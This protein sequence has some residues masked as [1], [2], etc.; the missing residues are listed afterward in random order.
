M[1]KKQ[2]SEDIK[3]ESTSVSSQNFEPEDERKLVRKLDGRIM[4]ILSI[5]YLFAYLDRSNLG[6][7][8]LL[9]LPKDTLNGDPTGKRFDWVNSV[10]FFAYILCQV[11]AAI[12]SKLVPPR[13]WIAFM[14]IGW[15]LS[16]TLMATAF[17]FGGL[18]TGRVFLGIFEA[19]FGPVIPL[20]FSFF[21]T[22]EEMGVR[23][24]YWFG[25][26]AVAGA[27][28][29]LISFGVQHV[30]ATIHNWSILFL[31][32]GVP[33]MLMGLV[34]FFF[35]PNR[36]ESTT[37]LNE[38]ERIIALDRMNR[39]TSGDTGAKV[40]KAHILMAFR[41]WRCWT[42]GVIY[43]GLN[44]ALA[45][46]SAFLP[47][48]IGTFGYTN[49]IA[50]L[51]TGKLIYPISFLPIPLYFFSPSVCRY[52]SVL[53]LHFIFYLTSLYSVAA[54]L[55]LS[56][57]WASDR[58]QSRGILMTVACTISGIGY[59]LLL[60]IPTNAH[61]R[62]FAVYCIVSGTYA[63]IGLIIA[64]FAHNLGSETKRATGIP[65]FMATG[66]CG[67]V[68]GSHIFPL[69]EVSCALAFLSAVLS[70][71]LSISYRRDNARRDK[72][73]GKPDTCGRVDTAQLADKVSSTW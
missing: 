34:A 20:Y 70:L 68:L 12:I 63:T 31:I 25:F 62:Y 3:L 2:G 64:W 23:M 15:G 72:L 7:A 16:S 13:I 66:Q 38:H 60:T 27:F 52:C 40:D 56:F 10:F 22:K 5:L 42:G 24:A 50:Q 57:S 30:H 48:I 65:I 61:V 26:A 45:S 17:D 4:V 19:G 54:I 41:D 29:G 33:A 47:T 71:V 46:I 67:S 6:N 18:M 36:P 28:G 59:V 21:Y 37:F 1:A 11:P 73:Y 69:T 8:R 53:F 49:A 32:E 39:G 14:A 44:C 9:G 43:F 55:L 35:L 51:L 58:L